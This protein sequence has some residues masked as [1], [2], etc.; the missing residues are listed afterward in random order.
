MNFIKRILVAI[1]FIPLLLWIY[2][3]GE[4]WLLCLL[5]LTTVICTAELL[6]MFGSSARYLNV[7]LALALF[8]SI[9][10][11]PDFAIPIVFVALLLNGSDSVILSKMKGATHRIS[12]SLFAICYPAIGFGLL[13][14]LGAVNQTLIPILA[15]LIWI[16]D[17]FAYF[18]GMT[19]GKH[20]GIFQC[21]PKKSL[22]GFIAGIVFAFAAS[23][24]VSKLFPDI[25]TTKHIILLGI[26]AGIFGQFGDLY[27]SVIKRDMGV[28][29]SSNIIPGHG[30]VLDRF[31]SILIAAPVL[32][33]LL[34][35]LEKIM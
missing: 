14:Q 26:S 21:S 13:Y 3:T 24:A 6:K 17:T 35:V 11:N 27:E 4:I 12:S 23:F 18:I 9:A 5:G 34:I 19:F 15:I 2:Y 32:Y 28:K 29:D 33:I 20:R 8:A 31:D 10:I 7:T 1:V 22:E 30:G 16:V 25:Y